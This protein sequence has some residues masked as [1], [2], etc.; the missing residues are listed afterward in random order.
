MVEL[1][2]GSIIID[3][4]D[5][6]NIGLDAVRTKLALVPQDNTLFMGTLRENLCVQPVTLTGRA[7]MF[8][9]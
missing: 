8:L 7:L 3:D 2:G 5:I 6:R 4:V 1:K 9:Q